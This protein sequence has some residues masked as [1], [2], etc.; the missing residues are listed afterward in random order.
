MTL[1]TGPVPAP[2]RRRGLVYAPK[3]VDD[4]ATNRAN[5]QAAVDQ[6]GST[7]DGLGGPGL[8]QFGEGEWVVS[9]P[10]HV[11]RSPGPFSKVSIRGLDSGISRVVMRKFTGKDV[12]VIGLDRKPRTDASPDG[13]AMDPA[14]LPAS[15]LGLAGR[16]GFRTLR[17]AH[18]AQYGGHFDQGPGDWYGRTRRLTIEYAI[19]FEDAAA[20]NGGIVLSLSDTIATPFVVQ[21][22][23]S[24]PYV[25]LAT[26]GAD[27]TDPESQTV[28]NFMLDVDRPAVEG[29]LYR[30]TLQVDLDT[31]WMLL[32]W[33]N[34]LTATVKPDGPPPRAGESLYPNQHAPFVVGGSAAA[35]GDP[36]GDFTLGGFKITADTIYAPSSQLIRRD[37]KPVDDDRYFADEAGWF[38]LL[39]FDAPAESVAKDR[40][41]T[42]RGRDGAGNVIE[43]GAYVTEPEH[44]SPFAM[45]MPGEIRDLGI[46]KGD[47][48]YGRGLV[49]GMV[50]NARVRDCAIS[51]GAHGIGTFGMLCYPLDLDRL[52][53]AGHESPLFLALTSTATA[54]DLYF[55][56]AYRAGI[57]LIYGGLSCRKIMSPHFGRPDYGFCVRNGTLRL[58]QVGLDNEDPD[59]G[60][61]YA[62]VYVSPMIT[63]QPSSAAVVI[64]EMDGVFSG[65]NSSKILLGGPPPGSP[66]RT[67]VG[68]CSLRVIGLAIH[69]GVP[70]RSVVRVLPSA[71]GL[72]QD[73]GIELLGRFDAP[74]F[75]GP[76]MLRAGTVDTTGK[77]MPT[78]EPEPMPE[79][80]P[81]GGA[82]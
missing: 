70:F 75:E 34:G 26:I 64:E 66:L 1:L 50:G 11:D 38:A 69:S 27:P 35:G 74:A 5:L 42:V 4:P 22:V 62:D 8:L 30:I 19:R 77:V 49:L 40:L 25:T 55:N 61:K 7:P 29:V 18:I 80:V 17:R 9:G 44:A 71:E 56:E 51:G 24:R 10:I 58:D 14:Y 13:V 60:S 21:Q 78:P 43:S 39:P 82:E 45:T 31:P 63:G 52:T 28:R 72:W 6:A 54:N 3:P 73:R 47:G 79:P 76:A 32:A 37:G 41:V 36:P 57:R 53:L 20:V 12:F 81:A 67:Q 59:G 16:T 65:P 68:A 23:N 48:W 2:A 33:V 46:V 15:P